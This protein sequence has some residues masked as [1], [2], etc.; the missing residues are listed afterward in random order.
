VV[1]Q[2]IGDIDSSLVRLSAL[3]AATNRWDKAMLAEDVRQ[4]KKAASHRHFRLPGPVG[5]SPGVPLG[6]P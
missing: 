2:V 4:A 1:H 3:P 6:G 5:V